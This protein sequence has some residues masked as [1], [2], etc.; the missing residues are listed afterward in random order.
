VDKHPAF[1]LARL[2]LWPRCFRREVPPELRRD[3]GFHTQHFGGI[4]PVQLG[5]VERFLRS[6]GAGEGDVIGWHNTTHPLYLSLDVRPTIRFMHL[7]TVMEMGD[8]QYR[9]IKAELFRVTPTARFVVS[10]MYRITTQF[11]RLTG[12]NIDPTTGYARVLPR[13][14]LGQFPFNQPVVFR[15]PNGR[16]LVHAIRHPAAEWDCKIPR[17]LDD[18]EAWVTE[19]EGAADERR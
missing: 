3:V 8:W 5:A 2:R 16:Y 13:W 1:D 6:Q 12:G 10:D 18:N 11:G 17:G 15:S 14:Q 9:Q 4:D 7:S 19:E